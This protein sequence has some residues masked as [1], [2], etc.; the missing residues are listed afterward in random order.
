MEGF[1]SIA[2]AVNSSRQSGK[3]TIFHVVPMDMSHAQL[4]SLSAVIDLIRKNGGIAFMDNEI[5]RTARII[6]YCFKD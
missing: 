2:E 5:D 3:T 1:Y 4:K 6:N